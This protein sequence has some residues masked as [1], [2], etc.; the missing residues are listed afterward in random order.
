[1]NNMLLSVIIPT[2]KRSTNLQRAIDSVLIQKCNFN[3]EII[4]VDDNNDGDEYRK[5]NEILLKKYINKDNFIYIKHKNNLNGAN[6]RNSGIE[7]S[8]GKY[9]TFLD[10]DDEFTETRFRDIADLLFTDVDFFITGVIKKRNSNVI[11]KRYYDISGL[12]KKQLIYKLLKQESFFY[13]GSNLVVKREI[14]NKING[15][16]GKF[17]R[18]QDMEFAIRVINESKSI[19]SIE[20]YSVIKNID[21]KSNVPNYEKMKEVK[22]IFLDKFSDLINEYTEREKINIYSS[23]Y[24]ELL[25]V[26]SLNKNKRDIN[27]AKLLLK[28]KKLYNCFKVYKL[29]LITKI[30]HSIFFLK[31]KE[32]VNK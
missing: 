8:K 16:D 27:S 29:L 31:I 22:K 24:Y 13:T 18:N 9:V 11:G 17:I 14:I 23:N 4:V 1:M 28:S 7:L 6:A 15:F 32:F 25:K 19:K 30:R 2:Y 10:D 21:D 20:S 12:S 26:A 3:Y 5:N